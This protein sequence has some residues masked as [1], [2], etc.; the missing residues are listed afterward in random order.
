[1]E[2]KILAIV[3]LYNPDIALLQK[4]LSAFYQHVD[5]ILLWNNNSV[6]ESTE[7]IKQIVQKQENI[8]LLQRNKNEGIATA[9]NYG[10]EYARNNGYTAILSMDQ[11]SVF[12]NF[13]LFKKKVE[14]RWTREGL[15][16]CGPICTP[17]VSVPTKDY[18]IKKNHIITS[19][20]L[21]PVTLL[22]QVDGYCS[23]FFVDGI[24][25]DLCVKARQHHYLSFIYEGAYLT[26]IYGI[27][28]SKKVFG[29]VLH[30]AGYPPHRLYEI[31]RN[32]II[33]YRRY[34]Y[35]ADILIHILYL[36]VLGF[37]LKG[38]FLIEG[39]KK[40]KL[41]AVWRGIKDGFNMKL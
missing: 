21:V 41:Q 6:E 28:Q 22:N 19:G 1:M 24:D 39:Q 25:I 4:N 29:K 31:F 37:V 15:C 13:E 35:P 27:P 2:I 11:D 20:M 9:L 26:Q 40:D 14:E 32:H 36:Y 10:W 16:L 7:K 17:E 34:H 18:F 33:I 30:S 5:K 8:L 3:V 12:H 23:D 38:V